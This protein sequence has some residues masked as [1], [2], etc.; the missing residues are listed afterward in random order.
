MNWGL[1]TRAVSNAIIFEFLYCPHICS[2][3][4][5][6]CLPSWS[7]GYSYPTSTASSTSWDVFWYS[8]SQNEQ[9]SASIKRRNPLLWS[10]KRN[11]DN[12]LQDV[13]EDVPIQKK[14]KNPDRKMKIYQKLQIWYGSIRQM[15]YQWRWYKIQLR[16]SMVVVCFTRRGRCTNP[17]ML[18]ILVKNQNP[19][20]LENGWYG[21]TQMLYII[22][23]GIRSNG[24]APW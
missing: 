22:G 3:Y 12:P 2:K 4:W 19:R 9:I 1:S 7:S 13:V 18:K 11:E 23:D 5:S 6:H 21:S 20:P 15:L 8:S 17:E 24:E 16:G 14:M 10:L